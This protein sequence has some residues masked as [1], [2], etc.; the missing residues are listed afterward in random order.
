MNF[1]TDL[2]VISLKRRETNFA[3]ANLV[4]MAPLR[5]LGNHA[6]F[7]FLRYPTLHFETYD[8]GVSG[9]HDGLR[10]GISASRRGKSLLTDSVELV[11]PAVPLSGTSKIV[12]GEPQR[13]VYRFR[14][15][16]SD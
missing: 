2:G 15:R 8:S 5:G 16:R 13:I 9:L 7:D 4:G 6:A 11:V 14:R 3:T 12:F 1:S 10:S